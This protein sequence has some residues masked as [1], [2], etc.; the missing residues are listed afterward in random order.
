MQT[1]VA[2]DRLLIAACRRDPV[3]S[4]LLLQV[5]G[6]LPSSCPPAHTV[7]GLESRKSVLT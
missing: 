2:R 4:K 6:T 1:G 3:V 7:R 5:S